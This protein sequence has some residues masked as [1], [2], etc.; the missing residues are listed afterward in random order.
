MSP[1]MWT[2]PETLRR[3]MVTVDSELRLWQAQAER[4]AIDPKLP[5]KNRAEAKASLS[6]IKNFIA[7]MNVPE[8]HRNGQQEQNVETVPE[9]VTRAYPEVTF[10]RWNRL[11][12]EQKKRLME[13]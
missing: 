11:S 1:S 3:R 9:S 2:H 4:D 5:G 8:E 13:N 10:E 12:R 7:D 6:A